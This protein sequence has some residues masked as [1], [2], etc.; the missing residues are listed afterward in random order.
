MI[1]CA[2]GL[3]SPAAVDTMVKALQKIGMRQTM[4]LKTALK[5]LNVL[6]SV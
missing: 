3:D 1:G 5:L 2:Y 6:L 4:I